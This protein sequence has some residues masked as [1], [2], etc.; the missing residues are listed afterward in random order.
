MAETTAQLQAKL[1]ALTNGK[2]DIMASADEFKST[3]QILREMAAVWEDMTDVQQA[4]AL[5]LLGGKRQG[6]I[7]SSLLTNFETVEEVIETS[8]DSSGSAMAENEKW[9]DSIEGK[10]YQFT[11][12][13]QNMWRNLID[14]EM[15]KGFIDFGTD[16][17][18]FLDTGAGKAVAFVAAMKLHPENKEEKGFSFGGIVQGLKDNIS[19]ITTAQQTLQSLAANKATAVGAGYDV[20]NVNAYAQAVANLTAKQQANLLASSGL[21]KEQ[22]QYALTLNKVDE[23]SQRE[24]MAHVHATAAKQQSNLTDKELLSNK[25]LLSAATLKQKGD[26]DSLAAAKW[27]EANATRA[28]TVEEL[29]ELIAKSKLSP[30]A[31]AAALATVTQTAANKGLEASFKAL[32]MSNPVGF[33]I[34]L[35]T[36]ILSLIPIFSS[37]TKSAEEA[38]KEVRQAAQEATQAYVDAKNEIEQNLNSLTES[39]DTN[40]YE[41]LVDEFDQLVKGVNHLGENVSLT[42]DEYSRYKSICEDIVGISPALARGHDSATAAIG[43]NADALREL[44]ELEKERQ[45]QNAL[46]YIT[47]DSWN[48]VVKDS[49]NKYKDAVKEQKDILS[50]QSTLEQLTNTSGEVYQQFTGSLITAFQ[51]DAGGASNNLGNIVLTS[52]AYKDD[53]KYFQSILSSLGYTAEQ[54][55]QIISDYSY[56]GSL[57]SAGESTYLNFGE[58]VTDNIDFLIDNVHLLDG[59][60]AE[61]VS[62]YEVATSGIKSAQLAMVDTLTEVPLSMKQF[63]DLSNS[64]QSFIDNWIQNSGMFEID[65]KTTADTILKWKQ[66]IKSMV[67]ALA[68]DTYTYT[69]DDGT[70]V[71]AQDIIDSLY[72]LDPSSVDWASYQEQMRTLIDYLWNAIGGENNTLGF[73]DK[74][75]L[76]L[77]F[78]FDITLTDDNESKMIKRYMEL[79]GVTEEEAREYFSSL[80]ATVVQRLLKVDWNLVDG[81]NID[82]TIENAIGNQSSITSSK[83]YSVLAESVESYNDILS[84]TSEVV[85]DNTE[86]TQEYKD[87]LLD[88]GISAEDL[89]ECFDESNPLIVK[90]AKALN[91]LVKESNKN[92]AA[93]IKLAKSNARLEYYDLVKQL[94]STLE[95]TDQLD[96][97]TRES[98]YT[99]IEQIDAVEHAIYKY[100]LLEDTLLG[101][102]NAFDEFNEAKEI[103]AL[104]TY[105]DSYVEMV[106]TMYDALFKTGQVG[107]EQFWTAVEH[108]VP[109]EVYQGLKED[110]DRMKAIYDYYNKNILPSLHLDED[111]FSMDYDSIENFVNKGLESG[112]FS[113]DRKDFDLVEGMNLEK[114]AELMGMTKTQ[115]YAFFAELDKYNSSSTEPSFLEQLDDSLEGKI[116]SVT[117]KVE[118]LNRRKLELLKDGGYKNH[119]DEIDA[120]NKQLEESGATLEDLGKQAYETWEQYTQN[121]AAIASLGEITDKTQRLDEVWPE[122]LITALH[123]DG[124]QTVQ[125]AYDHLLLQQSLLEEPTILTAQLAID[126]IDSQITAL[127]TAINNNDFSGVDPVSLGLSVDATSEEI[128]AAIQAKISALKEDKAVIATTFGIELSEEDK[129]SLQE[130]LAAIEEYTIGD[131]EFKVVAEGT[132]TTMNVLKQIQAYKIGNKSYTITAKTVNVSEADGTAHVNGTAYKKGSWGA[133]KTETALVGELGPEM[134]VRNGRWTTIGNKGAEFTQIKKG[135]IIFNHKQTEELLSKGYVTGR[136]KLHGGAFASGTAYSGLWTPVSPNTSQSNKPGRDFATTGDSLAKSANALSSASKS[137]SSSSDQFREVFDWI[138]IRLEE[139]DDDIGFKDAQLSNQVGYKNQNKTVSEIIALNQKLYDNLIAGANQYYSYA[140]TL[141]SKVPAKYR[142][143]AQDGTIAIETF[144]GTTSEKNLEAIKEYRDWVQKGDDAA[145]QAVETLTEISNLAKQ[146]VD[147][148]ASDYDNKASLRENKTD[149]L[150]AYNALLETMYGFESEKIYHQLIDVNKQNIS[151]L[152]EQKNLMQKELDAQVVAGNIKKYSQ[153]WYDIVNDIAEIDTEIIELNTDV[154]DFQDSINE[155][156]WDKFDALIGRLEAVANEAENLIDILSNKDMVDEMGNWTTEGITT[157]GLYAQQME[158]AEVQAKKYQEEIAYLNENWKALGYTEE[159][160][161]EKLEDLKDGQYD[162]IKAYHDSKDAIVDLNKER[163]DAVK[164]GIEK[165]IEAY[166][167]LI[168]KKKEELDAEKDLYDFQKSIMEK[169]KDVADLKRQ[170]AA[171]SADN[172]ASARAKRAQLEAE[173]AEAQADIEDQYYDRS[174]SNKQEAL[175]KELENYKDEKDAEM[176]TLDKYLEDT[177]KVVSDS[178]AT[179]QSNTDTVY[180]TLLTM[181]QEYSL[182]ITESLTSPWEEGK[183]AIQSFSEQFG[184]SMSAT[185][186]ELKQLELEFEQ[187]MKVL[188]SA[189]DSSVTTVQNNTDSYTAAE[190]KEPATTN[191]STN[192]STSTSTNSSTNTSTNKTTSSS[193]SGLVSSLSGTISYGQSGSKVKAL[194]QALNALGYNCGTV[195]GKFGNKTLAAVKKFQKAMGLTQDGKVGP[196]TKAKFKLKGYAV[197]STGIDED[198]W[199]ILDELG[200][201]LMMIPN[202]S[203]RLEYIRRGTSIIPSDISENLMKLGQLDPQDIL[204]RNRPVI[205]PSNSI[206]NTEVQ[207]DCSVG[208]LVNIEHCDQNTLPD[209]E[210]IINRALDKHLQNLNTSLKRYTRG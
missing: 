141:L 25:V 1:M 187:S 151:A 144:I 180:Q 104:N 46:S 22:I 117:N 207:L 66:T 64:S 177:E 157:L 62:E 74:N 178:L 53:L 126:N 99:T 150:D 26:V 200:P 8:M 193:N 129:M 198:Q 24:A 15:V 179:I 79:K 158:V 41:N 96:D 29:K 188:S 20:T 100:Q 209:V 205:K 3:T 128:K 119:K 191:T 10:T 115:A 146:A 143:A 113:G 148:I 90:N 147:N 44:I 105:G 122:D 45:R 82:S 102:N 186:E 189:G 134:L 196:K 91:K 81:D 52:D 121:D 169:E 70:V 166:E 138:E 101:V 161:I 202:N 208:T 84:Q 54:I 173:I 57:P 194:Q 172:S 171:L 38:A 94:G 142:E 154:A 164:N 88:L 87:S 5:E 60:F 39:S 125:A 123:L 149:Q 69:L 93:N 197:G 108:L 163:I 47:G 77:S 145:Q 17:V 110:S 59:N 175:D 137:L 43:Q 135:D 2:V 7:L 68:N 131:K 114:A 190:Y 50:V 183:L 80:P 4:A 61:A 33:W 139:I 65:D 40:L 133:P 18:N 165:E 106:Q 170:L 51:K 27:L 155:L 55:E 136:G 75:A 34:T 56:S 203:G 76:A 201:E 98:I 156:H 63:G 6:N 11:N 85:S 140:E 124:G 83:T 13:L 48:N 111:Q 32:C 192:T 174:V 130:E 185:V 14:S 103:D 19:Q 86:V 127:E 167:K 23:A 16:A 78:G 89:N 109:D 162:A 30:A 182:S 206:V 204:E 73:T 120:I 168:D 181:G 210:K 176:E 195:D 35:G 12:A 28:A 67:V 159:E 42:A 132:T 116:T 160:Y 37:F 9:L 58:W 31:K 71:T 92:I 112:V 72:S 97:A 118:D 152:Q 49:L 184:I 199:A 95:A 153:D 107:T 36:T 21:N